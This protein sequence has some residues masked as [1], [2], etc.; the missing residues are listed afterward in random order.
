MEAAKKM[1]VP[2]LKEELQVRGLSTIG[3]KD[4][5]LARLLAVLEDEQAGAATAGAEEGAEAGADLAD[6]PEDA[7]AEAAAG[8]P[9]ANE[10]G[11]PVPHH[12]HC[13]HAPLQVA[14]CACP[15]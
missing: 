12:G 1:R 13:A 4:E 8:E 2:E 6:A 9:A 7:P 15:S 14:R 10:P 5:L 3:K 11:V